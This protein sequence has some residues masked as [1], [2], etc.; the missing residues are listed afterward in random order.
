MV[1]IQ[2]KNVQEEELTAKKFR[3][4]IELQEVERDI[5]MYHKF[6][7]RTELDKVMLETLIN[8]RDK[9]STEYDQIRSYYDKRNEDRRRSKRI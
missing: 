2:Q 6:G 3:L 1:K 9:V 7:T 8:I 5:N 4:S